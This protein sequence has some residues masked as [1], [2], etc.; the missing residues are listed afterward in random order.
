[1]RLARCGTIENAAVAAAL[2]WPQSLVLLALKHTRGADHCCLH[3]AKLGRHAIDPGQCAVQLCLYVLNLCLH[4]GE[5]NKAEVR[6]S[7]CM[8]WGT[9][10]LRHLNNSMLVDEHHSRAKRA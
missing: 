6:T 7:P 4:G 2:R 3:A 5:V 10:L 1:M 8:H 9:R